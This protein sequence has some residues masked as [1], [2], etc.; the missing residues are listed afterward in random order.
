MLRFA[1][2]GNII[3]T[4]EKRKIEIF[5]NSYVLSENGI[6]KGIVRDLPEGW[7]NVEISDFGD[8]LI[9]PGFS[10]LHIHA[11]QYAYRG[12]GMD[13]ELLDWLQKYAFP[14]E[15]RYSDLVYANKAYDIFASAL[16]KGA[17]TRACIFA[18]AHTEATKLLMDK[19]EATGLKTFVGRVNMDRNAPD[20][21]REK[22]AEFSAKETERW[23]LETCSEYENTKPILTP[24]FI[25][26]CTDELMSMIGKLQKKYKLAVQ[27]HLSE[28]PNEVAWVSELC[29]SSAFYGDAYDRFGLFGGENCPTV[30]A[31]CVYSDEREQQL[32]QNR[33]VWIAHCP[34]SN[35]NVASGIAPVRT[36]LDKN[37]HV[38]LG[39]DI[40]GGSS[41]SVFR[42]IT[43]AIMC[44][45]LRWR[46]MDSSLKQLSVDDGFY[47]ATR[48][49]GSFFG[50]VGAFEEGFEMDAVVLDDSNIPQA[51]PM[52]LKDR[53]ER[54]CYLYSEV[55]IIAKCVAG[56]AIN[57]K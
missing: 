3:H 12:T 54:D 20:S 16:C 15:S 22:D 4:N 49:G 35:M 29:P 14:E 1:W 23:I 43:D 40:A 18:S 30:M 57:L 37:L 47:M 5:E 44:S 36:F 56:K 50:K 52:D 39:S 28:N 46:I 26:S 6:C 42:A 7:K 32:I 41:D 13:L 10:D 21:I 8:C 9:I 31:H 45:K 38:G 55:K 33:N 34:Q 27:S 11:P 17:T 51:G 48:G 24:R 25:P 53:F 2:K 19:M